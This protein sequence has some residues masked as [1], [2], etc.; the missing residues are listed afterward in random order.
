MFTI[1]IY[2][3]VDSTAVIRFC[4]KTHATRGRKVVASPLP[5][6]SERGAALYDER[7]VFCMTWEGAL[8]D[9]R[10]CS[11]WREE[12]VLY[13]D[14]GWSVWRKRGALYH[15][16]SSYTLYLK[17]SGSCIVRVY[18]CFQYRKFTTNRNKNIQGWYIFTLNIFT[19]LMK[20]SPRYRRI[21]KQIQPA[22]VP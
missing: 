10:G 12:G 4:L 22:V 18:Y 20:R 19:H 6:M 1:I 9:V 11:V 16:G 8:Y 3:P 2:I 15:F 21:K 13:D 5:L 14:S 7:V 17:V